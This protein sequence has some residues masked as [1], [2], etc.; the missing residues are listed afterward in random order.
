MSIC[1]KLKEKLPGSS[2]CGTAEMD[3]TSVH[4]DAGSFPGLAQWIRDLV[5]LW[6]WCRQA[7]VA[8]IHPLAWELPYAVGTAIKK[9]K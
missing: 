7:A 5:L 3:P 8:L 6:L 4:E 2:R 1:A 9:T